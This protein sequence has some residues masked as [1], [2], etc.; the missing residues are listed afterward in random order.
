MAAIYVHK[1]NGVPIGFIA[2]LGKDLDGKRTKRFFKN[3]ADA[4]KF[5]VNQQKD[6]APV[7]ILFDHRN[8]FL[9]CFE[10]LKAVNATLNEA[11][12]FFLKHGASKPNVTIEQAIHEFTVEKERVGRRQV[13]LDSFP[14]MYGTFAKQLREDT[15]VK[16]ITSQDI[17]TY[18]YVRKKD[19]SAIT[20][21]GIISSLS[22]LFNFCIKKGYISFNPT[23]K[24]ER[25]ARYDKKPSIL[26][27]EDFKKLLDK[28]LKRQWYDRIAAFILVGYC[29]VRVEEASKLCWRDINLKKKLVTVPHEIAKKHRFRIIPIPLNAR[30]WFEAIHDGRKTDRIMGDNWKT[31]L[32]SAIRFC[33][34][35]YEKNCIRHSYCSYSLAK[36]VRIDRLVSWMGHAGNPAVIHEHYKNVVDR[37]EAKKWFAI[38]P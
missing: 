5:I 14:V 22:V 36:G 18:V 35:S 30:K 34:I 11:T 10:R 38:V 12:E 31:L 25:P 3:E 6:P 4:E 27:P 19:T 29:G 21:R 33:H 23:E 24:V 32:R 28:C 2:D 1:R 15:L 8:E 17:E 37:D 9:Y 7:G 13:Y 26:T 20:K 16:D